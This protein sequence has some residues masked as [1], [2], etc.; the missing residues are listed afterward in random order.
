MQILHIKKES[1]S[2][3]MNYTTQELQYVYVPDHM[4]KEHDF[5]HQRNYY[6]RHQ[7]EQEQQEPTNRSKS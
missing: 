6:T 4:V 1:G 5:E 2:D 3:E 7:A